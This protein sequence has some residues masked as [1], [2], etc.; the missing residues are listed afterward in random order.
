MTTPL[1]QV[2]ARLESEG[3]RLVILFGSRAEGRER[4]ESDWD[5]GVLWSA[6]PPPSLDAELEQLLAGRVDLVDLRR[7]PPVLLMECV[8]RG[9]VL[10][11]ETGSEFARF[12][13]LALR[14]Y[15]DTKKLRALQE[16]SRRSFLA[17]R[18][19]P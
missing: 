17:A 4:P 15:E 16:Q 2:V 14:R 11:D 18:G 5:L 1:E 10:H 8:R 3:A 13:S 7:A 12:A 19:F 9:R 6:A